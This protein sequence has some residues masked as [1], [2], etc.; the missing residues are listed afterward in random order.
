MKRGCLE[1]DL[2]SE[3]VVGTANLWFCHGG[4]EEGGRK[5]GNEKRGA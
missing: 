3:A 4:R 5:V 2:E 1:W